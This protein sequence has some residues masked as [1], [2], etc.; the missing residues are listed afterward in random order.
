MLWAVFVF[1]LYSSA[2]VWVILSK[3]IGKLTNEKYSFNVD[4]VIFACLFSIAAIVFTML[5]Y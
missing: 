2:I 3:I 4:L 5:L 1:S